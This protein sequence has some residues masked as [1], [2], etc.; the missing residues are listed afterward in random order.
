MGRDKASLVLPGSA[1]SLA[2]RTA[3]LLASVAR[4]ALEVG[5]GRTG[6]GQVHE[7]PAGSGPLCAIAAG[8]R[9]LLERSWTGDVVVV[10]TDLPRL[11]VE[12]LAWLASYPGES[13]VIPVAEGRPQPL[14][15]RYCQSDL[16]AGG[17]L[18]LEGKRSMGDLMMAIRPAKPAEPEWPPGAASHTVLSD[19]DTPGDL[20]RLLPGVPSAGSRAVENPEMR[21]SI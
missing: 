9:A 11:T 8:W 7:E 2:A 14:C 1:E 17:A 3:R 15:A 12:F 6:L 20:F 13:S 21:P 18:A 10:A 4:P 16:A 5:P 19:V